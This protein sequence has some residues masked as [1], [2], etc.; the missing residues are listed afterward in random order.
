MDIKLVVVG[1]EVEMEKGKRMQRCQFSLR[2]GCSLFA[3]AQ[4]GCEHHNIWSDSPAHT[5]VTNSTH[6]ASQ[7]LHPNFTTNFDFVHNQLLFLGA[8]L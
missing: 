8:N 6:R 4:Y 2:Q 7:A 5:H 1:V 3:A